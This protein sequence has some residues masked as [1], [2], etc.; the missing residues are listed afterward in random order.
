MK[1]WK[2]HPLPFLLRPKFQVNNLTLPPL[3]RHRFPHF[4]KVEVPNG[5]RIR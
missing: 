2:L 5:G 1:L 3:L 4:D